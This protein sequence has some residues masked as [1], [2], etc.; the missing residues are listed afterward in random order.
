MDILYLIEGVYS[1]PQADEKNIFLWGHSMGGEITLKAL[2]ISQKVK[3]ASLWAP[4][5]ASFPENQLYFIRKRKEYKM[6]EYEEK[7]WLIGITI[8]IILLL[9]L[10]IIG[11]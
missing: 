1:I 3:S 11:H 9:S 5:S 10:L 4:V 7:G 2:E 8:S 6:E